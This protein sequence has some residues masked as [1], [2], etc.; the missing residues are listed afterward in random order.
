[1]GL[2][3]KVCAAAVPASNS[4]THA[5]APKVR[6]FFAGTTRSSAEFFRGGMNDNCGTELLLK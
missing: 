1:M 3:A 2:T 6:L 5:N 4:E